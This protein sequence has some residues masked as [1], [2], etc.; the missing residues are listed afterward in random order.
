LSFS[1]LS[2]LFFV[3][4]VSVTSETVSVGTLMADPISFHFRFGSTCPIAFAA[5]VEL[6]TM[7]L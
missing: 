5:Q 3:L 4:A 7:E 1:R 6:G 2:G